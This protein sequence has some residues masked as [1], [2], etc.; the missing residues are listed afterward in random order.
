MHTGLEAFST[1]IAQVTA[2]TGEEEGEGE[3]ANRH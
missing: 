3:G 1:N 2:C